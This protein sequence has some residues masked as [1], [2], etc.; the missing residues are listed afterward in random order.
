MR[1]RVPRISLKLT[2]L[3]VLNVLKSLDGLYCYVWCLSR[4]RMG[5]CCLYGYS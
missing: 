4:I 2:I 1:P 3:N 5:S